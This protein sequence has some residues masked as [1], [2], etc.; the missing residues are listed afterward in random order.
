MA[1]IQE[2]VRNVL[3]EHD[4]HFLPDSYS[5]KYGSEL[6]YQEMMDLMDFKGEEE[7]TVDHIESLRKHSMVFEATGAH[8]Q[9]LPL[10]EV[11]ILFDL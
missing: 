11:G 5:K 3:T 1:A 9:A 4:R 6:D 7:E 10:H 8:S 2:A